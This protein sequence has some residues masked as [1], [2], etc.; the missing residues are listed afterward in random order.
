MRDVMVDIETL[1]VA[2]N[3]VIVSIG[4]VRFDWEESTANYR[5]NNDANFYSIVDIESQLVNQRKA[6][7]GTI[8]WWMEQDDAVRSVLTSA[9]DKQRVV[10]AQSLDS[11]TAFCDGAERVWANDPQFD[12]MILRH[13]YMQTEKEFPFTFRDERSYRTIRDIAERQGIGLPIMKPELKHNALHDARHQ[14]DNVLDITNQVED[15]MKVGAEEKFSRTMPNAN[16][17]G[18]AEMADAHVP[19]SLSQL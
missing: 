7:W 17:Q 10:L 16:I 15:L 2:A 9:A 14:A 6:E 18:A 3:A 8:S 12:C 11:F 5:T 13:A 4:A 1:S 19:H